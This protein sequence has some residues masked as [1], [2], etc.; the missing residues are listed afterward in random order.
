VALSKRDKAKRTDYIERTLNKAFD[1]K[2]LPADI[3]LTGGMEIA[4]SKVASQPANAE[5]NGAHSQASEDDAGE[6]VGGEGESEAAAND[7]AALRVEARRR[8]LF[9]DWSAAQIARQLSK[10]GI[11]DAKTIAER[12]VKWAK[13]HKPGNT[14]KDSDGALKTITTIDLI[15]KDYV[16]L[17]MKGQPACVAR[18]A[19]A[20]P[21]T[22]PDFR[23]RLAP[24]TIIV[25][26]NKKGQLI[27]K[28][29][30]DTWTKDARRR[31][32]T[33]VVFTAG[34]VQ[35]H[36]FNIWPGGGATQR[37]GKCELILNH[38]YEVICA[39]NR[40]RYEQF[41][42]LLAW[43]VQNVGKPSRI[44]TALYSE[45]Q[46]TGK[47]IL[48][49]QV[50]SPIWGPSGLV[51]SNKDHAFGRFNDV[52]RGKS[53][54]FVDEANFAG[55]GKQA[56]QIK[57]IAAATVMTLEPKGLP[58][59]Q[60]PSALNIFMA[61]NH[62]NVAKVELGDARYWLLEVSAHR[63]G[64]HKYFA[65]LVYGIENGGKEAFLDFLFKRNVSNFNPQRDIDRNN[66]LHI[67]NKTASLTGHPIHWLQECIE[68]EK[69][70][71]AERDVIAMDNSTLNLNCVWDML[72]GQRIKGSQL[73]SAYRE[74]FKS[75]PDTKFQKPASNS[76]VYGILS[77]YGFGKDR[78]ADGRWRTIPNMSTVSAGIDKELRGAKA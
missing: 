70:V 38:I 66:E 27:L 51:I 9:E 8:A 55:D 43:Q 42:N 73:L 52:L 68:A 58:K 28:P 4:A 14:I 11:D 75:I 18:I 25:G 20:L 30:A 33:S 34:P 7:G 13:Q 72:V 26:F 1:C 5:A 46:Q 16:M 76:V 41:L 24:Q 2:L 15:N 36:E 62:R 77:K 78:D 69:F 65:E 67:E 63:V 45:A 74:W 71:G 47:G 60:L 44:V 32:A 39:S 57:A 6:T 23:T 61:T 22:L 37:K 48:L 29:A 49:E 59:M 56:D 40:G 10:Q 50:L 53:Y 19:D 64:D 17:V 35:P 21:I 12:A 31:V 3:N 54:L